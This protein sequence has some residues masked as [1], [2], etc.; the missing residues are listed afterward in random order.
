M[1]SNILKIFISALYSFLFDRI[2]RPA[3]E[4]MMA[5]I[6]RKKKEEEINQAVEELD[7]AKTESDK[8]DSFNRMP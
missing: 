4:A 5:A 7:N 3:Y 1:W 2:G 8:F 6:K